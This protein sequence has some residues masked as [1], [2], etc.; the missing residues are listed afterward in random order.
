MNLFTAKLMDH[1]EDIGGDCGLM[2]GGW[3]ALKPDGSIFFQNNGIQFSY[4]NLKFKEAR[5][6][7]KRNAPVS[8]DGFC[9]LD[10]H[11]LNL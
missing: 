3:V 9:D 10:C 4:V 7:L 5:G 1:K 11:L 2:H 6:Y 8:H